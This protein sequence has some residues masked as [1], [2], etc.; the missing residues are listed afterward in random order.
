MFGKRNAASRTIIHPFRRGRLPFRGHP[1][2][3]EKLVN[4]KRNA[5][6]ETYQDLVIHISIATSSRLSSSVCLG[7]CSTCLPVVCHLRVKFSRGL[8]CRSSGTSSTFATTSLSTA[9]SSAG[10][11]GNCCGLRLWLWLT[12]GNVSFDCGDGGRGN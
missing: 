11:L 10:S 8:R 12:A 4:G 9:T 7:C 2:T 1:L 5:T 6:A 3:E